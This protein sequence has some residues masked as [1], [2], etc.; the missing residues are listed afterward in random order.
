[1]SLQHVANHL[2]QQGRGKDSMLV[3]MTPSEVAGLRSLAHAKGG[4]LTT[5]PHTGL[6]EAGFLD[7]VIKVAAPIALGAFLGPA[8]MGLSAGL[9]GAAVGGI[10]TL[11]TGSLS[12]GLMAGLGAYG[13]SG[14]FGDVSKL[15]EAALESGSG[16]TGANAL[17]QEAGLSAV[18]NAGTVAGQTTMDSMGNFITTPTVA[19]VGD[20][21]LA[22]N[23][24]ATE[25]VKPLAQQ[26]TPFEKIS[27]GVK[28]ITQSPGSLGDFAAK[29]YKYGL[30]ALA[31]AAGAAMENTGAKTAPPVDTGY[32]RQKVFD[33]VSQQ[34]ITLAP[35]K[36]KDWGSRSFSDI[37]QQPATAATGGIVALAQGGVAHFDGGGYT[38]QQISDYVAGI[39]AQGGGDKEIA[40]A[41]DK[42]GV[43]TGQ[44]AGAL[45]MNVGD[46]QSRYNAADTTGNYY[47]GTS[48]VSNQ[49][50]RNAL[51]GQYAGASDATLANA[52]QQYHIDPTQMA[53]ATGV[54]LAGEGNIADRYALAQDIT[55]Q[56]N[57]FG[58]YQGPGTPMQNLGST[59]DQNWA[60]YMDTHKDAS[61]N[62]DPV[63]V[64]EMA[65]VTGISEAEIAARYAA[66]EAKLHPIKPIIQTGV[67]PG[68]TQLPTA[69]TYDNGAFGN[70]GSGNKTGTDYLGRT[71]SIAT[72]G[73]LIT[74][75]D[76]TRTVVPNVPGRPYGGLTGMDAVK[77]AYTAGGGSLGYYPPAPKTAADA[78][79]QF[80]TMTGDSLAAYNFLMGKGAQPLK[81][82]AAQVA[83][84]YRESVMGLKPAAVA[85]SASMPKI[86]D[87]VT[88]QIIDNP[89]YKAANVT[90]TPNTT[91]STLKLS[92]GNT[93]T[94]DAG[95]G[96]YYLNGKYYDKDGK[97]VQYEAPQ[98][99]SG[100]MASYALGGLGSLGGYSDGGRL[101]RGP[102]DGVSD[103]IPASIGDRQPARLADGEFVVP[104][105]IVSEIGNGSTEAGA[106][107]LYQM[108]DRV[109]HARRKTT[110]KNKVATNTDAAKYLPA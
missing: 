82:T 61:G 109:Q 80:N 104:A 102:G 17:G 50:I 58:Q 99:A 18:E 49:D 92:T 16:L 14:L 54:P 85:N 27:S 88:R 25:A 70:Y 47:T 2:A 52:M 51:Q 64:K 44:L 45:G 62:L 107:K 41:M 110:G 105:R 75:P 71:V 13:G 46:V 98:L 97:E 39:Q 15:G 59:Y 30:A 28:T 48:G 93:A 57:I 38:N 40:Q 67:V 72:P 69:T 103:S 90:G 94:F 96:Y 79:K 55:K 68:T 11:A 63:A 106:R 81:T 4:D 65:R 101:L 43:N 20:E 37:Y 21:A 73:D 78:E 3:H 108:M 22:A 1:M 89:A 32:I 76:Q 35:V 31:P 36:A 87:P 74:N 9:A 91:G 19:N 29:N 66:A 100:G 83:R 84:P 7:D 34:Y 60:A 12:R 42:F 6:P 5:N 8:G 10:T 53:Y 23:E 77:S 86:F 26:A 24:A 56:G 95:S 33:P